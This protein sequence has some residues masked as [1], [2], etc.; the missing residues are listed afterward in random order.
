GEAISPH[1]REHLFERFYKVDKAHTSGKGTGLGLSIC[2]Q[3]MDL[4]GQTLEVLPLEEGAG[5]RFTLQL[6]AHTLRTLFCF[7]YETQGDDF[8]VKSTRNVRQYGV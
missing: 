4:H 7:V 1:D 3:I 5:F 2:K 8:Y 6:T